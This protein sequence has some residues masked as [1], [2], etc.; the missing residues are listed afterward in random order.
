MDLLEH[1]GSYARSF[2]LFI[3]L[4]YF[5]SMLGVPRISSVFGLSM[6]PK[7]SPD[8]ALRDR[9][10][11][12]TETGDVQ[13]KVYRVKAADCKT[14]LQDPYIKKNVKFKNKNTTTGRTVM[15]GR[16]CDEGSS[17]SFFYVPC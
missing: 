5:I 12:L 2:Y 11:Q 13:R 6:T 1:R 7:Q 4:F 3:Y 10:C 9:R 8:Y 14:F 16:S 15:E 17:S